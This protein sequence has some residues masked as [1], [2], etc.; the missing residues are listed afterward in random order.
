MLEADIDRKRLILD[1]FEIMSQA[2]FAGDELE[3]KA[4]VDMYKAALNY[5]TVTKAEEIKMATSLATA[6]INSKSKDQGE[7]KD[8]KT[9]EKTKPKQT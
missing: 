1:T 9:G 5:K 6:F 3:V 7:K 2:G 8:G 4:M